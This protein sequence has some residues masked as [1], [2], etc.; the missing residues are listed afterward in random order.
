VG[1][2]LE[3][4]VALVTGASQGGIGTAIAVRCAAEGARV[5]VSGRSVEGLES[6]A[7][8]ISA[9]GGECVVLPRISATRSALARR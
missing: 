9:V 7:S 2:A 3:G 5:A 4:R 6:C 8:D 1:R